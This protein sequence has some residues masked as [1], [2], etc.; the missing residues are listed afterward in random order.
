MILNFKY[1]ITKYFNAVVFV[2]LKNTTLFNKINSQRLAKKLL[3]L[4]SHAINYPILLP[5]LITFTPLKRAVGLPCET[6][7]TC[8]GC[9]FPSEKVPPKR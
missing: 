5:V 4:K 6:A 9:P 3:P 8:P 1:L 2:L 7:L